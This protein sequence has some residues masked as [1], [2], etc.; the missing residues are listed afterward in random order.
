VRVP[1]Y[2]QV[3]MPAVGKRFS[4]IMF[5]DNDNLFIVEFKY[6]RLVVQI[7]FRPVLKQ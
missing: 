3:E 4:D 6:V 2:D 5:M 1:V 7:S